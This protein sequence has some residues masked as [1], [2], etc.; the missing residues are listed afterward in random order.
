M[1]TLWPGVRS[2]KWFISSFWC[3]LLHTHCHHI[4]RNQPPCMLGH[5]GWFTVLLVGMSYSSVSSGDRGSTESVDLQRAF[6]LAVI[7]P[8]K[9]GEKERGTDMLSSML[10]A[11]HTHMLVLIK[12]KFHISALFL[13]SKLHTYLCLPNRITYKRNAKAKCSSSHAVTWTCSWR[14][15][16]ETHYSARKRRKGIL[17]SLYLDLTRS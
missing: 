12:T 2:H 11:I 8:E 3:C 15:K 4:W 7:Q 6:I 1:Q 14:W 13:Q 17:K 16:T 10:P 5:G 9:D